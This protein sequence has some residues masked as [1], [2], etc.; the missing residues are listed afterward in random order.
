MLLHLCRT[1]SKETGGFA[2]NKWLRFIPGSYSM[3]TRNSEA[4]PQKCS[5]EER[6][7]KRSYNK[8]RILENNQFCILSPTIGPEPLHVR[9][10]VICM[11][12]A[13]WCEG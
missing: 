9:C 6:K 5:D 13:T 3:Q 4:K 11:M 10:Q 7:V 1:N 8:N 12:D 2:R